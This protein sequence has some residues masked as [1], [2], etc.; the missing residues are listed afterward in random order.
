MDIKKKLSSRE[1]EILI[2][3]VFERLEPVLGQGIK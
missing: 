1:N 3:A 2:E